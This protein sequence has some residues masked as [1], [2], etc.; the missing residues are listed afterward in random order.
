MKKSLLILALFFSTSILIAQNFN[1]PSQYNNV[2]DDNNDGFASFYLDE[3]SFEILANLNS[4]SYVITNHETQTEAQTGTNALPS[5]YF[6]IIPTTQT[7]Y[8]RIVTV[9]SGQVTIMPYNLNVNPTPSAPTQTIFACSNTFQCWDLTSVEASIAQGMPGLAVSFYETQFDA[10]AGINPIVNPSCYVSITLPAN[11]LPVFYRAENAGTGC[12]SVGIIELIT[13]DCGGS[14]CSPPT[15]LTT[16][17]ITETTATLAWTN[18]DS[19]TQS[20]I[21]IAPAGSP[22]P[23]N[24]NA[25]YYAQGSPYTIVGLTCGTQYDVYI[26]TYCN[27]ANLSPWVQTTFSTVA[28]VPQPGQPVDLRQCANDSGIA[29]FDISSN[30]VF[31][32]NTLNPTEYTI[33][34]HNSQSDAQNDVNPITPIT[35]FCAATSQAVFSRLENNATQTFQILGFSLIVDTFSSVVTPLN[36]MQQ[37]DDNNDGVVT[38]DL[39]TVQAQINT[40]N[41]LE[42]YPSLSNAQNQVVPFTNPQSLNIG[43]QN[44]TTNVFVREIV[45]NS[46]DSIYSFQLN[47]YS[48]CNLA[49]VCSQANSLCNSLG[50]PFQNTINAGSTGQAGCLNTTPNQTWFYLP[51]SGTG[52]I[53]LQIVQTSVNGGTSDVDYVVYGPF[54][55]LTNAC[56]QL[57]PNNIVSCSYSAAAVEY[58]II[59]NAQPGHYYLMMVTNFSN[60]PGLITITELSNSV[61]AIDCS[62]LRLNAFLDSNNNGTKDVG[63]QNF[64]LGQFTYEV[65][66]NGNVHNIISPTGVYNI[67]DTN[68]TNSYDLSYAIDPNYV[69]SYGISTASYSNVN[70]VIGAGMQTYNFPITVTQSYNDLAVNIVPLNA[71]RPGFTYQERIVY[72]NYG[73]QTVASGT[74]TFSNDALVAITANSQAG[75]TTTANG[76]TYNFTNLLPFETRTITVTMQ[77]PN[78]PTVTL[79]NLLTSTAS[80]APITGDVVPANNTSTCSQIIIGAYDPNDKME[81]HGERILHSSFTANDYLYYTI[82]FENTG[83]ASAINVRVNDV[84]DSRLDENTIRMIS[85]SHNYIM[86]RV[87]NNLT[88]RFDNIQLP[89]SVADTNI[90]KGYITFQLKPRAGYAVGDIIPNTASIYFDFNPPIITNTF[91]TEF[92]AQLGINDFENGDFVFYPNPVADFITIS[93]K[94]TGSVANIAVYDILGKL[95]VSEKPTSAASTQTI[96]M[97]SLSRGVYRLEV[98][99]DSNLKVVKKFVKK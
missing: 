99:S 47:A 43:I 52:T 90:G 84:L 61:G 12:F 34:Y 82:R 91:N 58:P 78:I 19:I 76:F 80:I 42:Y 96:D 68:A 92:V 70:V 7:I 26:R 79:G 86:D 89:V 11:Q 35:S 22:P 97:S 93:V 62:G 21:Y 4:Q 49:S 60:Q 40:T 77:V 37:C 39:T 83:T 14:T 10:Q 31:I 67:Y 64:P 71:P 48:N 24:N 2:C 75:T 6:N 94:N 55:S 65:N 81:S 51:V 56:S 46:C 66:D 69:A 15:N 45:P 57:A 18:S 33:T 59:P 88:W 13:I 38:F 53:N 9:A 54:S 36:N 85:A 41:T 8:A 50:V 16:S 98:T 32:M 3:V 29:C 25:A 74:I 5:P 63:E 1:Q 44:P 72:T 95:I 30:T 17:T 87:D 28:C 73:N 23:T 27:S 20:S